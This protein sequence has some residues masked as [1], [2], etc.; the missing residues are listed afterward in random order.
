LQALWQGTAKAVL[1]QAE[2]E[3]SI[4]A[5]LYFPRRTSHYC[6]NLIGQNVP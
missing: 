5:T 4:P 1:C 2:F 6:V 3:L